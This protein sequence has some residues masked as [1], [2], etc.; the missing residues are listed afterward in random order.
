MT[1]DASR[2]DPRPEYLRALLADTGLSQRA[3]AIRIGISER[4]LRYYLAPE[5][6]ADRRIAPYPVQYT[7]EQLAKSVQLSQR[8]RTSF[9]GV[10]P[11]SR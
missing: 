8:K 2:H 10:V 6:A 9:V 7:I 5:S 4:L 11:V 3:A 1:P